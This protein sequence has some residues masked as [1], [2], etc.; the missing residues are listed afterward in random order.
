MISPF[1]R[2]RGVLHAEV[3]QGIVRLGEGVLLELGGDPVLMS[4]GGFV[5]SD[6]IALAFHGAVERALCRV[7]ALFALHAREITPP[8]GVSR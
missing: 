7:G 1:S 6:G 8:T 2:V 4:G 3:S 5:A